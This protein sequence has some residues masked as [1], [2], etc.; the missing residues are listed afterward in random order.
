MAKIQK[1]KDFIGCI[2]YILD[3][4]KETIL[5]DAQG[6]RLKSKESI[7]RSF[8]HAG[9]AKSQSGYNRRAYLPEFLSTR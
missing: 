4:Q 5:L 3:K 8:Y 9:K 2:N 7:I 1:G 6:V